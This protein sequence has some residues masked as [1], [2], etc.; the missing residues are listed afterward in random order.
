MF[1]HVVSGEAPTLDVEV[2]SFGEVRSE[3]K[4]HAEV[5]L[6]VVLHDDRVVRWEETVTVE[7]PFDAN[8]RGQG[9]EALA[10]AIARALGAAADR[11][12]TGL[13]PLATREAGDAR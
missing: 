13:G 6:R 2:V 1:E 9:G 10:G 12:A 7:R 4:P 11:V 8:G 5:R 3:P